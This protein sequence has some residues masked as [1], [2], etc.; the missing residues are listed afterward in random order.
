MLKLLLDEAV[1]IAKKLNSKA[2]VVISNEEIEERIVEGI[3]VFVAPRSFSMA[4]DAFS[5]IEESEYNAKMK[6]FD[7]FIKFTHAGEY[8]ST[9]L[10]FKGIKEEETIVGVINSESVKGIIVA[11][12]EQSKI[13]K[14]VVECSE[15]INSKV[16]KSILNLSLNIAHKGREGRRIGTGFVIGDVQ[17]V[18]KR[19]RQLILNPYQGH[20]EKVRNITE[21]ANWESV[22]EFAQLDGVFI[23]D[24]DGTIVS[25]GRYLEASVKD[26]KVREGLGGRHI[27]CAAITR[28]T[29]AV[30]VV[31]SESGDVTVYK[32]GNELIVINTHVF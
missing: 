13:H 20:S 26:L 19:S 5:S 17:E 23:V 30:S 7:R 29:E 3:M 8:I 12:P 24:K 18:M 2:I 1:K 25:A 27:A 22:M 31:I 32:D 11:N 4:F 16:L 21:P 15:R 28:E 9:M 6:L 10:Y 14:T